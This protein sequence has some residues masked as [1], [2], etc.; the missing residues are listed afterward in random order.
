MPMWL[1][2]LG[3]NNWKSVFLLDENPSRGPES[4]ESNDLSSLMP[5]N[6]GSEML[7]G[8]VDEAGC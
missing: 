2:N 5:M 8:P 3:L 4:F 7:S 1:I 6:V